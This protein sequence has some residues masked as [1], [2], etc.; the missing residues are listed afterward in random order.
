MISQIPSGAIEQGRT[1]TT[2][3]SGLVGAL[4]E[5]RSRL[6]V[7]EGGFTDENQVTGPVF[8]GLV[9][10]GIPEEPAL[11]QNPTSGQCDE[12]PMNRGQSA[13]GPHRRELST[14]RSRPFEGD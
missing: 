1:L 7:A 14:S 13:N 12:V 6:G 2:P 3:A 5:D 10:V 9:R 11:V 8:S 4:I